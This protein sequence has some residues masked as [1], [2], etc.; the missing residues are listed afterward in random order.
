MQARG[1]AAHCPYELGDTIEVV[2]T[3][4]IA[5]TGYPGKAGKALATITDIL[6]IHSAKKGA[7]TFLYELDG[8][9]IMQLIPWLEL[10]GGV[11]ECGHREM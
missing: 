1:F 7:V 11:K 3:D 10:T 8:R 2:I 5:I 4:S 9:E 6:T